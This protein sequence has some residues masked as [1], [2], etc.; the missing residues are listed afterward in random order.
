MEWK[1]NLDDVNK[2][3]FR[4]L[5]EVNLARSECRVQEITGGAIIF[6]KDSFFSMKK[7]DQKGNCKKD[8]E[9]SDL[10]KA[11]LF[12]LHFFCREIYYNI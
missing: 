7:I 2:K 9:E 4:N 10:K 8:H 5:E 6:M 12:A 11:L 3:E 1:R